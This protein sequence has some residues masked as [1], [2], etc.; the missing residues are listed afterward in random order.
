MLVIGKTRSEERRMRIRMS[1]KGQVVLPAEV[2]RRYGLA[3]GDELELV[4][5]GDHLVVWPTVADPETR[6]WGLL[7]A[8]PGERS[9]VEAL[10]DS[11]GVDIDSE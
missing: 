5:A 7:R 10:L 6:L 8:G 2:R 4:D 3:P 1:V 11:R 9:L